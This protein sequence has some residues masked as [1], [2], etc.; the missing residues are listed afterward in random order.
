MQ[1]ASLMRNGPHFA[2]LEGG[3]RSSAVP[4]AGQSGAATSRGLV[5]TLRNVKRV[6]F[7][8]GTTP[9]P[10]EL[11]GGRCDIRN[12]QGASGTNMSC[13]C[14]R[15]LN[16][17]TMTMNLSAAGSEGRCWSGFLT[18]PNSVG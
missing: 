3:G 7:A 4:E 16:I 12:R 2:R 15:D 6:H 1:I 9:T 8:R 11:P 5:L 14:T 17:A 18:W 13:P 10:A